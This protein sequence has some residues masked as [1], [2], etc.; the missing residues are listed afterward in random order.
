MTAFSP[1]ASAAGLLL[2]AAAPLKA[3]P[4]KPSESAISAD[5]KGFGDAQFERMMQGWHT[6]PSPVPQ[7][8]ALLDAAPK[9]SLNSTPSAHPEPVEGVAPSSAPLAHF[10]QTSAFGYRLHPILGIMKNHKGIDLA[11]AEGTPIRAT[12]DG[13]VTRAAWS[14]GYGLMV[15]LNHRNHTETR[16][17]H[18]S[19]LAVNPGERVTKGSIIGYVGS[20]GRSTGPHLHYEVLVDGRAVDPSAYMR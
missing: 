10:R 16:Y 14:G 5:S 13:T 12:A 2:L 1:L 9:K 11:A 4:E 7:L 8:A 3:A 17:G 6:A 15:E 19:R 18:M 20:T